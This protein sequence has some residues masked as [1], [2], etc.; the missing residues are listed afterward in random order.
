MAGEVNVLPNQTQKKLR[1]W[2]METNFSC[3]AH[4][5]VRVAAVLKHSA[6]EELYGR[7]VDAKLRTF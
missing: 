5:Q 6:V 1:Q 7:G 4:K 2:D 3:S